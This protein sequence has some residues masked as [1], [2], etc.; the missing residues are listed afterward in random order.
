VLAK[1]LAVQA[2]RAG[3][4]DNVSVVLVLFRDFW[5]RTPWHGK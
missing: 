4:Q 3:S 2:V 5:A 1:E